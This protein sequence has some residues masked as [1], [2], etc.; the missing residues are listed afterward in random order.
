MYIYLGV[1]QGLYYLHASSQTKII[2]RDIRASNVLVDRNPKA[3][4]ADFGNN[5]MVQCE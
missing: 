3:K 5:V 4:I 1:D 2:H